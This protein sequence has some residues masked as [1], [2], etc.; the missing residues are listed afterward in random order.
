[1]GL[2]TTHDAWH[3]PYSQFRRWRIWLAKQIGLPLNLMNG[4]YGWEW[5]PEDRDE[6]SK[7]FT[8]LWEMSG[9]STCYMDTLVAA[10]ELGKGITWDSISDPLKE[11]LHHSDCDGK[12]HWW[13]C[14]AIALRLVQV[15]RQSA[16]SDVVGHGPDVHRGCY[17]SMRKAT[18]RFAL[19]CLRAWESREH[20]RFH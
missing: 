16:A 6:L 20:L 7:N 18:L 8:P 4:F 2:D 3:G 15:Y 12:I 9:K 5:T 13:K 19:G 14:K 11:V 17:D 1:M 10:Q